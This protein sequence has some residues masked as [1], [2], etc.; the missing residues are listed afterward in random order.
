MKKELF[1]ELSML[2]GATAAA[3]AADLSQSPYVKAPPLESG[4]YDW[5]GIYLGANVG[6]GVARDQST[7]GFPGF[8][9]APVPPP[10]SVTQAPAGWLGGL[11]AGYNKQLG[12][13]VL[14][15]EGDWQ[16]SGQRDSACVFTCDDESTVRIEQKP[17]D[18]GTVRGRLGYAAGSVLFYLTGGFAVGRVDANVALVRALE[19]TVNAASFNHTL[20]GGTVGGGIEAALFGNWTGKVEYLYMDLGRVSD[21]FSTAIPGGTITTR[22]T[23]DIREHIV[24]AGLNY[25]FG[26][27]GLAS[28]ETKPRAIAAALHSWSG[29]YVGANAGYGVGRDRTTFGRATALG[30]GLPE[31]FTIAP[32][33]AVG[34]GQLG[35]NW[36]FAQ[37]LVGVETDLQA[38]HQVDEACVGACELTFNTGTTIQRTLGWFGTA[39]GR[40]GYATGP[41]LLYMTGGAAYG[42]VRTGITDLGGAGVVSSVNATH[43]KGGWTLG[44]GIEGAIS[45]P[46]SAKLEYLYVDL[47][48]V[49]DTFATPALFS[50]PLRTT[51]VAGGIHDHVFRAGV[52][53]RFG[54]DSIVA[55]Y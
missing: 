8:F 54:A 37:W 15:I 12:S 24:R 10:E 33:G 42:Q 44:G 51:T 27:V 14:G 35:Y 52:N 36:Q 5:T 28:T 17:R 32:G 3:R 43:T 22:V 23:S 47:G 34:G 13:L 39:R 20:T 53:Y 40:L 9:G 1:V 25:R 26:G 46:W 50:P 45:G 29:F 31:T 11:Q 55:K 19:R 6:Y 2:I 4:L 41:A 18:F 7:V 16:W 48:N 30:S 21:S 38:A 49:S